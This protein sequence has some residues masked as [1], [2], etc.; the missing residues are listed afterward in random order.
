MLQVGSFRSSREAERRR[1]SLALLG[2]EA[3]VQEI[4]VDGEAIWHRVQ[5][6]PYDELNA[7]NNARVRLRENDIEAIALK[8]RK[9]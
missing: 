9:P 6:G 7:L 2:L 3:R 4:A 5:V 8:V 1:A